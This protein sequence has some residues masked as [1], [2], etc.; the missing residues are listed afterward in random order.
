[1]LIYLGNDEN[2]STRASRE[3][4]KALSEKLAAVL[5]SKGGVRPESKGSSLGR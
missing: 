3:T 5:K 1:M 4:V 2:D